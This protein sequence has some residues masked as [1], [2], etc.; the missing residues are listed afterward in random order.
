[1]TKLH[2][3]KQYL[4]TDWTV[5]TVKEEINRG[6]NLLNKIDN[7][8]ITFFGSHRVQKSSKHYQD[9]EKVA[10]ELG[11]R[12]YAI[13]TGGGPG[14]MHAANSGAT[15]AKAHS[16]GLTAE[17]LTGEIV[18]EKIHT[19]KS[20]FKFLFVRRFIMSIKSEALIFYPGGYGT[21]N[22]LFEFAVLMQT[23]IV[24]KVPIICVNRKYW[25]G[26]FNWLRNNPLQNEF[27]IHHKD[28]LD[29]LHI[30]DGYEEII[31]IIEE[32]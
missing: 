15:K 27:F 32:N 12:N 17:L 2:L 1:M 5:E 21:L 31:K 20:P 11:M 14:I 19:Q 28:D 22:E 9:C 4:N 10:F 29:L 7:K 23:G 18:K 16:I 3:N 30:V 8:I 26:L 24:D 6:L 13:L 25:D